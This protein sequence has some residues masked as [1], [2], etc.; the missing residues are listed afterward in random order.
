LRHLRH[1]PDCH[2]IDAAF[3]GAVEATCHSSTAEGQ[4]MFGNYLTTQPAP[5]SSGARPDY[6]GDVNSSMTSSMEKSV[7]DMQAMSA[8]TLK[9]QAEMSKLNMMAST[10]TAQMNSMMTL[11]EAYNSF[12]KKVGESV[13]SAA[14]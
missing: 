8:A 5:S 6:A 1:T 11:N 7:K 10:Q 12:L 3:A 2:R 4:L 13:K 9:Q 14:Q